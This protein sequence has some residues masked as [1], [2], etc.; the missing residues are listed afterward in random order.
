MY[1]ANRGEKMKT[2]NKI[3]VWRA[4]KT[5][6]K[7]FFV[8]IMLL[9]LQLSYLSLFPSVYGI[10]MKEFASNRNLVKTTLTAHRGTIYDSTGKVLAQNVN[11]YTVIA[12]L[13]ESRT[14][15]P[16]YPL[17]VVD[18]DLTA[19]KLAPVLGMEK[20]YIKGLLTLKDR[21]QV[22]LGPGGRDI[23][24]LKKEEI[25]LLGLPG[26]D[27]IEGY[28]RDYP[29][30]D[31]ASYILGYTRTL[32][33]EITDA[34]G[35]KKVMNVITGELGIEAKYDEMLRGT[36][37]FLQYE[38]DRFGYKIPDTPETRIEAKDGNDIYLTIDSGIQRFLEG[39]IKEASDKYKPEWALM[40]VMDAK[41]G[42]I[43]GSASSPSFD[44]NIRNIE[45]YE[46]P[47]VSYLY[48]PGS[49]MKTYTYMC[50]IDKGTYRGS[51]KYT[52]GHIDFGE[53]TVSDWNKVGWGDIT[54]DKGFEYSSNVAIAR[55][56]ERFINKKD[57][58]DCF[59]R[60]GFGQTTGIELPREFTGITKFN[61]PIEVATAGFGQ[62]ITT[63]VVQHLQALTMIANDGKMLKP[64]IIDKIVDPNTGK[65]VY[66]STVEESE[67][68]VKS[69]TVAKMKELMY[70][71]VNGNDG[72]D[73]TG[74]MYKI[75]GFDVIGKTGTAEIYDNESGQ[76][77]TGDNNNIFSFE[78]MYPKDDPQIIIY[79]A[80]KKPSFGKTAGTYEPTVSVMNSIAKYYNMFP[81]NTNKD[82]NVSMVTLPSY[83]NKK[84]E[85]VKKELEEKKIVPII[86]GNGTEII[87]QYPK[88]GTDMLSY[89]KLIL[90]T[91][92]TDM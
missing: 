38:Q 40:A 75:D 90:V 80:M 53:D 89:D 64:H 33:E 24:E 74:I 62:G 4:P 26:I 63:T 82:S 23:D 60:Y 48:E 70:Q 81:E 1:L 55:M 29:N 25:E 51:D 2:K 71:V 5:I 21:Y 8:F 27:F 78:G 41:T 28:R 6:Y 92:G 34:K 19:E 84:V 12:Y 69:S 11:S 68:I 49:T 15:N 20:D 79:T 45:N 32:E 65:I 76:Y 18:P 54:F 56:L 42:R 31:F 30:H 86:L 35:N 52:S 14:T 61:Y 16:N 83:I 47:L 36:D 72:Y 50:A 39:A 43:L 7:V 57:L 66:E 46:N 87:E 58:T 77:L 10:N 37:G 17:H 88:K 85:G 3:P 9:F 73:T 22:E 67:Q 13:E 91:N 59:A 44:P